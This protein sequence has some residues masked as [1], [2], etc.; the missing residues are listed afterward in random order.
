MIKEF[1]LWATH[2]VGSSDI[3]AR[4]LKML[5]RWA[6]KS[7]PSAEHNEA[8]LLLLSLGNLC[9][10]AYYFSVVSRTEGDFT[11]AE[12]LLREEI[13]THQDHVEHPELDPA[14]SLK[15]ILFTQIHLDLLPGCIIKSLRRR[16]WEIAKEDHSGIKG[17]KNSNAADFLLDCALSTE[18]SDSVWLLID[19]LIY[20]RGYYYRLISLLLRRWAERGGATALPKTE[21]GKKALQK[22]YEYLI[23]VRPNYRLIRTL[24]GVFPDLK[25]KNIYK[26]PLDVVAAS[27][28]SSSCDCVQTLFSLRTAFTHENDNQLAGYAQ[29]RSLA[30]STEIGEQDWFQ[31]YLLVEDVKYDPKQAPMRI[32]GT[33][34]NTVYLN[35]YFSDGTWTEFT[36]EIEKAFLALLQNCPERILQFLELVN[37][38]SLFRID[39]YCMHIH[40][41]HSMIW[42]LEKYLK[43]IDSVKLLLQ[44]YQPNTAIRIYLNSPLCC[45]IDWT[46]FLHGI[47]ANS[48]RFVFQ[49]SSFAMVALPGTVTHGESDSFTVNF[50]MYGQTRLILPVPKTESAGFST[51]KEFKAACFISWQ[52]ESKEFSIVRCIPSDRKWAQRQIN[53][54]GRELKE[55]A[56]NDLFSDYK[57]I[58]TEKR[59]DETQA[60]LLASDCR[61]VENGSRIVN[62]LAKEHFTRFLLDHV[63]AMAALAKN[64]QELER[65]ILTVNGLK[66]VNCFMEYPFGEKMAQIEKD[67]LLTI[68]REVEKEYWKLVFSG[69][70]PDSIMLIYMNT[71]LKRV[72]PFHQLIKG[73]YLNTTHDRNPE[74]IIHLKELYPKAF[75]RVFAGQAL[76]RKGTEIGVK[77]IS[78][79]GGAPNYPEIFTKFIFIQKKSRYFPMTRCFFTIDRYDW[80]NMTCYLSALSIQSELGKVMPELAFQCALRDSVSQSS[81]LVPEIIKKLLQKP[82]PEEAFYTEW[83]QDSYRAYFSYHLEQ[84]LDACEALQALESNNCFRLSEKLDP[85]A[86]ERY[87]PDHEMCMRLV[88]KM[89]KNMGSNS[90]KRL[91][92]LYCNSPLRWII[93]LEEFC[94]ALLSYGSLSSDTLRFLFFDYIFEASSDHS[95][96]LSFHNVLCADYHTDL[97]DNSDLSLH[98]SN[99]DTEQ[100][101]IAWTV[102]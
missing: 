85:V 37:P 66:L 36:L 33:A 30:I 79:N 59:F 28:L 56:R 51:E 73:M 17:S 32:S 23:S 98:I 6:K 82:L 1:K 35:D 84:G 49:E 40:I 18:S 91:V 34:S 93:P 88:I 78:F 101:K 81:Q 52:E 16:H 25:M 60:E 71:I 27:L 83:F 21:N 63:R 41:N 38:I 72:I 57:K 13:Q 29:W 74:D 8:I 54:T 62:V 87:S 5:S 12:T 19:A 43:Q 80:K 68:S 48:D 11:Q 7:A 45:V 65:F 76:Y 22:T 92:W 53:A 69:P 97:I 26:E 20:A 86:I 2:N 55:R 100:K 70:S 24:H 77:P 47:I 61:R 64:S 90:V 50:G 89:L 99:W 9:A 31:R 95:G 96:T 14:I 3:Q 46:V 39:Y 58:I 44:Y 67:S 94:D 10:A 42:E 4:E 15:A 75:A 102:L